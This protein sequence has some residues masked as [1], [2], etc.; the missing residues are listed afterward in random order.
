MA[1]SIPASRVP[2]LSWVSVMRLVT[3]NAN[4]GVHHKL[5]ALRSLEP[6]V[7]VVPECANPHSATAAAVYRAAISFAWAGAAPNKGLA[8]L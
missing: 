8:V 5:D 7:A 6:D 3:W 2:E 4:G 1:H